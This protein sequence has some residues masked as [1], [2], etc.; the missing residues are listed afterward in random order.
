MPAA[1]I[2]TSSL[3]VTACPRC[4]GTGIYVGQ[5]RDGSRY[6]GRC[7]TCQ[8][9]NGLRQPSRRASALP[10][11]PFVVVPAIDPAAPIPPLGASRNTAALQAFRYYYAAEYDWLVTQAAA[12]V[13]FAVSL[14]SGI[15]RYGNLTPRQLAAVQRNL[16]NVE[17]SPP[18]AAD[19]SSALPVFTQSQV[20]SAINARQPLPHEYRIVDEP[21]AIPSPGLTAEQMVAHVATVAPITRNTPAPATADM[22]RIFTAFDAA[23]ASGL[24]KVR[25]TLGNVEF[26]RTGSAFRAGGQGMVAA[27]YKTPLGFAYY[28]WFDRAGQFHPSN[29]FRDDRDVALLAFQTAAADPQSAARTHGNDTGHCSCC[30]RLLTDPVS[31]MQ[32]IGPVCAERFFPRASF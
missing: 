6:E 13:N 5:R 3:A 30:R 22:S 27:Y 9:Y 7:Y 25:L 28:G 14:L 26:R 18:V 11:A 8:G 19:E 16:R 12:G 10:P 17:A 23:A 24:Q 15:K 29:T 2:E 32:G 1:Q 4:S 20:V 31:V 21:A